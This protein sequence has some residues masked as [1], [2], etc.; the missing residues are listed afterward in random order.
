M[1]EA[2]ARP[3]GLLAALR[4]P[5]LSG[6]LVGAAF[7]GG[8]GG[9]AALAPLDGAAIASGVLSVES[10]RKAVQHLEGGIV[11]AVLVRNGDFVDAGQPLIRLDETRPRAALEMLKV[12][13]ASALALTARLTA[14]RDGDDT[15]RFPAWLAAGA[16]ARAEEN[17]FRARRQALEGQTAILT[18]QISQHHEEIAALSAEIVAARKQGA[19]IAQEIADVE[20]LFNKG[21]ERKARLLAL[22]RQA[23]EIEGQKNRNEAMIAKVRRDIGETE[24]KIVELRTTMLNEAVEG[25]R[26]TQEQL[27]KLEEEIRAAED[28]LTRTVVAAPSAGVVVNLQVHAAGAVIQPGQQLM[29]LVPQDDKLVVEARVEPSDVDVVH[30]GLPAQ[31]K[32]TAFNQRFAPALDG[33]VKWVSADRLTDERTGLPY[34]VARV[35]LDDGQEARLDEELH[36]GMPAEVM[37]ATGSRTMLDY[38][39]SPLFRAIDRAGR[40]S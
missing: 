20:T 2:A 39:V 31:V 5:L 19:L 14:E 25:L 34:Y 12:Q 30:S 38:L 29:E 1:A 7:F 24:L 3:T 32:L 35:E 17:V 6:L 40:E 10:S 15:V 23:A 27:A 21:L 13:R 22:Q 26:E 4:G 36:P 18:Q 8:F 9:W 37:I 33:R 28:V 16:E 11:G